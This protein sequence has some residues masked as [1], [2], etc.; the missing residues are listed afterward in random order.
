MID[1][2]SCMTVKSAEYKAHKRNA[3]E[4]STPDT[5]THLLRRLVPSVPMVFRRAHGHANAKLSTAVIMM[6]RR[7]RGKRRDVHALELGS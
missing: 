5:D 4:V 3:L 6:L 1:L 2:A 7:R